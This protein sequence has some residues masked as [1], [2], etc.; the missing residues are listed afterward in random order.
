MSKRSSK[1]LAIFIL[2]RVSSDNDIPPV[3]LTFC[4][5]FLRTCLK[6]SFFTASHIFLAKVEKMQS[7]VSELSISAMTILCWLS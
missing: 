7:I 6:S 2:P 3:T 1:F 5:Q 4:I